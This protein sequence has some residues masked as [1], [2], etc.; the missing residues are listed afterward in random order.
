MRSTLAAT[1][2]RRS[3]G[4][5]LIE[6]LIIA[7]IVIIAISGFIALMVSMVS[8]VLVS[9]DQNTMAYETQG[10]L[11]RI[12]QD[13]R[14]ATQFLT[15]TGTLPS[16]QGSNNNFT[17]TT[18]FTNTSNTLILNTLATDDNPANTTRR[19]VYYAGQP[20]ACGTLQ[21]YNKVFQAQVVYFIKDSS[22]WRRTLVPNFNFNATPNSETLCQTSS[23]GVWQQNSCSPGYTASRCQT[24]DVELMKGIANLTVNYYTTP[25]STADIGASNAEAATTLAA[26]IT[27]QKTTAGRD[28]STTGTMRAS[29]LNIQ[30]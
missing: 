5:T 26:T 12:E 30:R 20:N 23:T 7:P 3:P 16:P 28:V 19:L 29:K 15:T 1:K 6:M 11:D 8:D 25:G 24:N 17:G 2:T 27:G 4:F 18:A 21:T 10:A 22:L 14:L 13:T 9:R